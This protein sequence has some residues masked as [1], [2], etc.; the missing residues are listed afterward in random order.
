MKFSHTGANTG[1]MST[2]VHVGLRWNQKDQQMEK[3]LEPGIM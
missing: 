3:E 1:I 2:R